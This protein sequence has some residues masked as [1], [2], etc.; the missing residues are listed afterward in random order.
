M[1]V[2]TKY[3]GEIDLGEDKI[4]TFEKGLMGFENFTKYTILF[5]NE[6]ENKGNIMWFQSVEEPAFALPVIS[7]VHVKENYDPEVNDE[8]LKSLGELN[9]ENTC[10]L[11][12]MTVTE[13]VKNTTAN[14]KAPLVINADTRKGCQVIAENSDYV[15][16]YNVYDAIQKK[17]QEKGE[18]EC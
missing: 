9:D 3:F 11:L 8:W 12:T 17:K 5:D 15:V 4:I 18:V 2:K 1:L 10:V 16:K 14:L 7:P 6:G 13:D